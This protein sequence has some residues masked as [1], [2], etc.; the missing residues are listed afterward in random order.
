M[1]QID[2]TRLLT[3]ARLLHTDLRACFESPGSDAERRALYQ[4]VMRNLEVLNAAGARTGRVPDATTI[5]RATQELVLDAMYHAG[6]AESRLLEAEE[7]D[8]RYGLLLESVKGSSNL[9]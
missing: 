6:M 1:K 7:V 2:H 3:H 5:S 9:A 4:V 8:Q